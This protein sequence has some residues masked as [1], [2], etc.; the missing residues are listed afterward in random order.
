MRIGG[1][2]SRRRLS[3]GTSGLASNSRSSAR[4]TFAE[5]LSG[6]EA[7]LA[8]ARVQADLE[9]IDNAALA[10][11]DAPTRENLDKYRRAIRDVLYGL[12]QAYEVESVT[13][14]NRFGKRTFHVLVRVVDQELDQL[15]RLVLSKAKDSLAIAAK[16]DDIR[17]ILLDSIR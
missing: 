13:G 9:S 14:F 16:I 8:Q 17:G 7:D 1:A 6:A 5:A 10:L 2:P 4:T 15:A 3:R 12:L 11:R